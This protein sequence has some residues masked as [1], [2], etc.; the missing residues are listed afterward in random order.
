MDNQFQEI[1]NNSN[2]D[3]PRLLKIDYNGVTNVNG[4]DVTSN[5]KTLMSH[6]IHII[7][8]SNGNKPMTIISNEDD[9]IT[10][11]ATTSFIIQNRKLALL[12]Q[13]EDSAFESI[14]I[15]PES[16]PKRKDNGSNPEIVRKTTFGKALTYT[17]TKDAHNVINNTNNFIG[18]QK[19]MPH[20]KTK[21]DGCNIESKKQSQHQTSSLLRISSLKNNV[22]S[23]I[24]NPNNNQNVHGGRFGRNN[25]AS[26]INV[27]PPDAASTTAARRTSNPS[28][29]RKAVVTSR[30]IY[31]PSPERNT[32]SKAPL[33]PRQPSTAKNL[34]DLV[35]GS[36]VFSSNSGNSNASNHNNMDIEVTTRSNSI[37]NSN[38]DMEVGAT[39]NNV[40]SIS[41]VNASDNNKHESTRKVR[42][43]MSPVHFD[44]KGMFNPKL[45]DR[46]A[47]IGSVSSFKNSISNNNTDSITNTDKMS[48]ISEDSNVSSINFSNN[49]NLRIKAANH[50]IENVSDD[51]LRFVSQSPISSVSE[52][53]RS[54]NVSNTRS[55]SP[56]QIV[57]N[58]R[59]G[60]SSTTNQITDT[61]NGSY[62]NDDKKNGKSKSSDDKCMSS[63]STSNTGRNTVVLSN[64]DNSF[65]T[66][67]EINKMINS[68]TQ[69]RTIVKADH[70]IKK[71]RGGKKNATIKNRSTKQKNTAVKKDTRN[72]ALTIYKAN[73]SEH[74]ASHKTNNNNN[75]TI[76]NVATKSGSIDTVTN[77]GFHN[78]NVYSVGL[79]E[80]VENRHESLEWSSNDMIDTS[81]SNI[82][83]GFGGSPERDYHSPSRALS[84][85]VRQ[86]NTATLDLD[87][88]LDDCDHFDFEP[89]ENV[90]DYVFNDF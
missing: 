9:S 34:F 58:V 81:F 80:A 66:V 73:G 47:T 43:I 33:R 22:T 69:I 16:K 17:T 31:K 19:L 48:I 55:C 70:N 87:D 76:P 12:K 90:D 11:K 88:D 54:T 56:F 41:V 27:P 75:G 59:F 26:P 86:G 60:G 38:N 79:V 84:R 25:L 50:D 15:T 57:K 10:A 89:F 28:K 35:S 29:K 78:E 72:K 5:S 24:I 52:L 8:R 30:S 83:D 1:S 68:P 6:N 49:K 21:D 62:N 39:S 18:M 44:E 64:N 63:N 85:T 77:Q 65:L 7:Q 46:Y 37:S 53:F 2:I 74:K 4:N 40:H 23:F 67:K 32:S 82:F 13:Q 14:L 45:D 42:L 61:S 20:P 51:G 3:I 71:T 36:D